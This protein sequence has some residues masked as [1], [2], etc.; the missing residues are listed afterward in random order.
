MAGALGGWITAAYSAL[1]GVDA[2]RELRRYGVLQLWLLVPLWL[3]VS[4][5]RS[6]TRPEWHS[7]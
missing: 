6:L 5:A 2:L 4:T 3:V 1:A 7:Q